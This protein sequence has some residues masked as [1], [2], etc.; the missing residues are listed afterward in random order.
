MDIMLNRYGA[1]Y[2]NIFGNNLWVC[3]NNFGYP[4]IIMQIVRLTYLI[5]YIFFAY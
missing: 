3:D 5:D 2:M 1:N 4:L